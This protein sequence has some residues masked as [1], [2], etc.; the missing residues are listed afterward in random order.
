MIQLLADDPETSPRTMSTTLDVATDDPLVR[1]PELPNIGAQPFFAPHRRRDT[2][3]AR[4]SA[5]SLRD[6]GIGDIYADGYA[7]IPINPVSRAVVEAISEA[8][9]EGGWTDSGG[10]SDPTYRHPTNKE[11]GAVFVTVKSPGGDVGACG[12]ILPQIWDTVRSLDDLTS[13]VLL[14]VLAAWT[15]HS[16]GPG[17]PV[18]ISADDILD[19][20]GVQ[21]RQYQS[22]P[23]RWNHGHRREDRLSV[24]RAL[25]RG[26]GDAADIQQV[27]HQPD[28]LHDLAIH[29]R[30]GRL[31]GL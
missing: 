20:R 27:V 29:H 3:A 2:G 19:A 7:S 6:H 1:S 25:D 14:I 18:W 16:Q 26:L 11:Q 28:H 15:K 4:A 12:D 31:D 13:D 30:R 8:A 10:Q 22:E 21:R 17:E 5:E 24:G 23:D 9:A